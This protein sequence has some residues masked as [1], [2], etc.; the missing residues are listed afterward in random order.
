MSWYPQCVMMS[1]RNQMVIFSA[2]LAICDRNPSVTG[3]FPLQGPVTLCFDAFFDL[4][5]NKWLN[6][7]SRRRWFQM[8]S[9]SLLCHCNG[10]VTDHISHWHKRSI[11]FIWCYDNVEY[12]QN[13]Q[14]LS[15]SSP[16]PVHPDEVAIVCCGIEV[17]WAFYIWN[18]RSVSCYTWL[19][20]RWSPLTTF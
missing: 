20:Y 17:W 9:L 14:L 15:K 6:Q 2:S 10:Y 8:P 7:Q 4:R 1:W 16:S 5:L 11:V 19:W 13:T 18:S 3:P 12:V